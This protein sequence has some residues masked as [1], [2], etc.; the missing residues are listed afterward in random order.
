MNF[1]KGSVSGIDIIR[2]PLGE[3]KYLFDKS[4]TVGEILTLAIRT[5]HL[6]LEPLSDKNSENPKGAI[7]AKTYLSDSVLF[8]VQLS[9]TKVMIRAS[10][11]TL[12]YEGQDVE[13]ILPDK[14]WHI[15][16]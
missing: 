14:N 9:E 16:Q 12:I 2:S 4:Y 6:E 10:G 8:E 5:Q 15:F 7:S 1:I 3:R 11:D 13:I